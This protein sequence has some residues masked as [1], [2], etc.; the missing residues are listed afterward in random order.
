MFSTSVSFRMANV[1]PA[2]PYISFYV[3]FS[4]V[5]GNVVDVFTCDPLLTGET[6]TLTIPARAA[7][8]MVGTGAGAAGEVIEADWTVNA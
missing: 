7:I 2:F 3:V 6:T 4:D 5:G 1:N 8:V